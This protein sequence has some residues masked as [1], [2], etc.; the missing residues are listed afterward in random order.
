M[1]SHEVIVKMLQKCAIYQINKCNNDSSSCLCRMEILSIKK[2]RAYPRQKTFDFLISTPCV[3][4]SVY[5]P[6]LLT[7]PGVASS[8]DHKSQYLTTT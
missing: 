3:R 8:P 6:E 5:V 4:V 2:M 7:Q 1:H